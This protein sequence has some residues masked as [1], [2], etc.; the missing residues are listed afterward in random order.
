MTQEYARHPHLTIRID[1]DAHGYWMVGG[2][3]RASISHRFAEEIA[4]AWV[5]QEDGGTR[6]T[7]RTARAVSSEQDT[8]PSSF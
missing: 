4:A 7:V 5:L 3:F 6:E 1:H 8:E 2:M